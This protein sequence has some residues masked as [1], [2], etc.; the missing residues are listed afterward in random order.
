MKI[1]GKIV[2]G[3]RVGST[4]TQVPWVRKQFIQKLNVDPYPGTLNLEIADLKDSQ[5]FRELK[6][7]PGV[8]I[9]PEDPSFCSARCYPVLI[10]GRLKGAIVSPGVED[11]PENKMEL[12]A[13]ENIK[14][15]L[16][17][18]GGDVLEVEV[19]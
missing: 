10:N 13:S 7:T 16:S 19:L 2:E 5:N 11:Y 9:I 18:K 17:V 15:I 6:L 1:R 8:E 3:L 4:F 12:I 14:E